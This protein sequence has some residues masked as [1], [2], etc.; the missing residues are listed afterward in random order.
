MGYLQYNHFKMDSIHTCTQRM[1]QNCYM[2]SIGLHDAYYSI[3]V[4][5][6]H[7]KYLKFARGGKLYQFTCLTQGLA[8]MCTTVIYQIMK[9]VFANLSEK[10]HLSR[11]YLDDSW[12]VG[13]S[14]E[15][16]KS[17]IVGLH[18]HEDKFVTTPTQIIQYLGLILNSIDDCV[19]YQ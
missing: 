18:P 12:L 9:P 5:K 8:C 6:D 7:Q 3:P 13:Y 16:G 2:G 14:Y 17:S 10:R 15:E 4:H 11:T 1:K 19:T